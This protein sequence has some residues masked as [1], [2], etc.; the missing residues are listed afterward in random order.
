MRSFGLL[1][2]ASENGWSVDDF[3]NY[4]DGFGRTFALIESSEGYLAGGYA[5]VVWGI[6]DGP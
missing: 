5:S 3:H 2:R 4:C 6:K 1:Y